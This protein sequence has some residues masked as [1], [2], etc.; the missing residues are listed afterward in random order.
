MDNATGGTNQITTTQSHCQSQPCCIQ[1]FY[2]R[3]P[4]LRTSDI[5]NEIWTTFLTNIAARLCQKSNTSGT[6]SPAVS[7][8]TDAF[9]KNFERDIFSNPVIYVYI[10]N[11]QVGDTV[12]DQPAIQFNVGSIQG[13]VAVGSGNVAMDYSDGANMRAGLTTAPDADAERRAG[14]AAGTRD[15]HAV[16]ADPAADKKRPP[17]A[18]NSVT[19]ALRLAG[20]TALRI[21]ARTLGNQVGT[22]LDAPIRHLPHL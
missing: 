17:P 8:I 10:N 4:Q 20:K 12:M 5:V 18:L 16:P 6:P 15:M 19:S 9:P 1:A 2:L 14:F 13:N 21:A 3:V 22:A 11:S 7:Q